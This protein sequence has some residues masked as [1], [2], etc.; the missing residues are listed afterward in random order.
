MNDPEY[1]SS[2]VGEEGGKTVNY[3]DFFDEP[4]ICTGQQCGEDGTITGGEGTEIPAG[5][6]GG[7]VG[8]GVEPNRASA[9]FIIA[10]AIGALNDAINRGLANLFHIKG[11]GDI[12]GQAIAMYDQ[13]D[14]FIADEYHPA[15]EKIKKTIETQWGSGVLYSEKL[16]V[17]EEKQL[18]G[19]A[20]KMEAGNLKSG[21]VRP[22]VMH[23]PGSDQDVNAAVSSQLG[24]VMEQY[25]HLAEVCGPDGICEKQFSFNRNGYISQYAAIAKQ[26]EEPNYER[27]LSTVEAGTD[28]IHDALATQYDAAKAG[29]S[30]N[31]TGT[32]PAPSGGCSNNLQILKIN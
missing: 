15:E 29:A 11:K 4:P 13:Y 2:S 3:I 32:F 1:G 25:Q 23:A 6:G 30:S 31:S 22:I 28:K 26:A 12:R 19:V 8:G 5:G 20:E 10:P 17:N 9:G 21:D 27:Y 14:K 18:A 7:G 24:G 16:R